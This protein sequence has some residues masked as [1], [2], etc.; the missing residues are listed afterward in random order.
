MTV[1]N[2]FSDNEY[3]C[4]TKDYK[5]AINYLIKWNYI[6]AEDEVSPFII[7]PDT[8]KHYEYGH[9]NDILGEDWA[10]QMANWNTYRFNIFWDG[11]FTIQQVNVIE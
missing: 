9:L 4:T 2:V 7:N 10:D 8:G 5:T 6:S 11:W 1:Y 3:V